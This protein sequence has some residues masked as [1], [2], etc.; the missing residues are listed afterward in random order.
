[1]FGDEPLAFD[2]IVSAARLPSPEVAGILL[3]LELMELVTQLPG[4]RYRRLEK[5]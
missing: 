1:L 4:M 3:E 2:T 5:R